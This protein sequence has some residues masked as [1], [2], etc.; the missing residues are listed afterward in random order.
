MD[1]ITYLERLGL[2]FEDED[3]QRI[4]LNKMYNTIR[5]AKI[6]FSHS[7]ESVF[8]S[9]LGLRFSPLFSN[10][11]YHDPIEV[12][13]NAWRYISSFQ[14]FKSKLAAIVTLVNLFKKMGQSQEYQFLYKNLVIA[15]DSSH[16]LYQ[17]ETEGDEVFIFPSGDPYLDEGEVV[18]PL[19]N[20]NRFPEAKQSFIDALKMYESLDDR[21]ASTVADQFRKA[22]ESFFQCFF[23]SQ[24]SLENYKSEYGN[25]LRDKGV[26][27]ELA[28]NF[29]SLLSAYASFN[30]NNAKHHNKTSSLILEYLLYETGNIIRL[31][32]TLKD[33]EE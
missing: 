17:V 23:N 30:N 25:Y 31:L 14:E 22:L 9:E 3:K 4:F 33:S 29:V 11:I 7:I 28:G 8:A 32:C 12:L 20:L 24:K 5:S 15:L 2:G 10:D 18:R 27:Q 26:S 21:N 19:L 6:P 13:G 16:I 1:Y